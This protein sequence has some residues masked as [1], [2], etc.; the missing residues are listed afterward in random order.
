[1]SFHVSLVG[2]KNLSGE[3]YR[4]VR[5]AI[6]NGPLAPGDPLPSSRELARILSVSRMT[7]TVAYDRLIA[8]G[9][10]TT[11]IGAGTFVSQNMARSRNRKAGNGPGPLQPNRVW[12]SIELPWAFYR[13]AI[14]NFRTGVPDASLF[15]HKTWRRLMN[16]ALRVHDSS[17]LQYCHPAGYLK[18][19]EMI[20]RHVGI[21]RGVV[22]SAD[23]VTITNGTQQA[24]DLLARVLLGPGDRIAMENPGYSPRK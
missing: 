2:R 10:A 14:F 16:Q 21:S 4:Q 8:E 22:A 23:D 12:N 7:A 3:I 18:L 19:R 6:L 5:D 11:R 15:P 17:A 20:A 1:M 24:L 13:P 9:F